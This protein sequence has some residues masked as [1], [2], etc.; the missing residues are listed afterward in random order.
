MSWYKTKQAKSRC[1]HWSQPADY[2]R[3]PHSYHTRACGISS[4]RCLVLFAALSDRHCLREMRDW[5][6]VEFKSSGPNDRLRPF[7]WIVAPLMSNWH[8]G[9]GGI[10]SVTAESQQLGFHLRSVVL[11][12]V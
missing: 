11:V 10:R 8:F 1:D 7:C 5:E 3:S 9:H 2:L 4:V 6:I 12:G